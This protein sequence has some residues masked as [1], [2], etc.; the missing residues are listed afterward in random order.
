MPLFGQLA[1]I[2]VLQAADGCP[3]ATVVGIDR[4]GIRRGAEDL[5]PIKTLDAVEFD[6]GA[7]GPI[8]GVFGGGIA[9]EQVAGGL[10]FQRPYLFRQSR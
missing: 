1:Q 7:A 2:K 9:V 5:E 3:T 4:D 6:D 10:A 8:G